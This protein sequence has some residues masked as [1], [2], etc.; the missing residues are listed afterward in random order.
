MRIRTLV[1]K[2]REQMETGWTQSDRTRCQS[3]FINVSDW[4]WGPIGRPICI[5]LHDVEMAFFSVSWWSSQRF[6]WRQFCWV[7]SCLCLVWLTWFTLTERVNYIIIIR[8]DHCWLVSVGYK[9]ETWIQK[10]PGCISCLVR[11]RC[12]ENISFLGILWV[13][14]LLCR[15]KC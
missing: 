5:F 7:I 2:R 14:C 9:R 8:V 6:L 3:A 15:L 12:E 13:P 1:N 4:C 11:K 10:M